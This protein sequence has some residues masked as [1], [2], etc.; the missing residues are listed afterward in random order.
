MAATWD[1]LDGWLVV[2]IG[3]FVWV[4]R[5]DNESRM[6]DTSH[7]YAWEAS[8]TAS[9]SYVYVVRTIPSPRYR[10][11]PKNYLKQQS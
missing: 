6:V 7:Y 8:D 4:G 11:V 5:T 9:L 1:Y 10:V 3:C 2:S